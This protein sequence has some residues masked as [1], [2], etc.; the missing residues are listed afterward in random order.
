[1]AVRLIDNAAFED[2]DLSAAEQFTPAPGRLRETAA[3][4][5]RYVRQT[6]ALWVPLAFFGVCTVVFRFTDADITLARL[7]F[8]EEAGVRFPLGQTQPWLALYDYGIC[9][10]WILGCGGLAVWLLAFA[11]KRLRPIRD[12]G[13]FLFL[14]LILGPG[15]LVNCVSKPYC[16][17]PRPH[18][19]KMFGGTKDFL[20]VLATGENLAGN[21]NSF[22][23]GHASMGFY[24]M[25]PAFVLYRRRN[26]WAA[27]FLI[28]GITA[29]LVIGIARMAAGAH[30]A[31][32]VLWAGG[33]VYFTGLALAGV[34]RFDP[35]G[36]LARHRASPLQPRG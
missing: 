26:G 29:G 13:L 12:E 31:S 16:G 14:M 6:P 21:C 9:P 35:R 27:F 24:L 32:D 2:R 19:T 10:A 30:F 20:P 25:A 8:H 7:F 5:F 3:N 11:V 28:L 33:F 34:F 15:V 18:L 36:T 4:V 17:R 22:P 23:S 1:M